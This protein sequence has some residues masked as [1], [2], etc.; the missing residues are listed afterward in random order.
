MLLWRRRQQ[1]RRHRD[2]RSERIR[3]GELAHA[4]ASRLWEAKNSSRES[5]CCPRDSPVR[6]RVG[7]RD[8]ATAAR[9]GW[10]SNLRSPDPELTEWIRV[11]SRVFHAQTTVLRPM[12]F[13]RSIDHPVA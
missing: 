2:R 12:F 5:P 9:D 4:S 8:R 3:T 11:L 6:C 13:G 7:K 10:D 1:H